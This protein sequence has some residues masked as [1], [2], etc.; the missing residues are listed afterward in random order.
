MAQSP[1]P[2]CV[3]SLTTS[4]SLLESSIGILHEGVQDFPRLANVLQTTRHFEIT[5][6]SQIESAQSQ[7]R[8]EIEPEVSRLLDRVENYLD[9]L[10]RRERALIARR[11]LLEGRIREPRHRNSSGFGMGMGMMRRTPGTPMGTPLAGGGDSKG[12][13]EQWRM[14]NQ[15]KERLAFAVERLGLQARQKERQLRKSMAAT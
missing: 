12:T 8:G 13:E 4:L 9:R 1:L 5:S 14:L 7:I 3:A 10:E 15:K 11:E 6:E 2:S